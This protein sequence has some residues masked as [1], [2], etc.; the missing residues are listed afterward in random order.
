M[1]EAFHD[2]FGNSYYHDLPRSHFKFLVEYVEPET[3]KASPTCSNGMITIPY[4]FLGKK[5]K[6]TIEEDV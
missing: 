6:I 2:G 4:R 1:L 5:I 3:I